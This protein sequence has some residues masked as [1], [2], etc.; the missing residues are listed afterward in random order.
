MELQF[1]MSSF[2]AFHGV[3]ALKEKADC[4][5]VEWQKRYVTV[6]QK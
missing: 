6:S 2:I 1:F 4:L 3:V 5:K